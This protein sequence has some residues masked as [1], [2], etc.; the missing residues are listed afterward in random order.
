ME[1]NFKKL[2]TVVTEFVIC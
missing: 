1:S 2:T